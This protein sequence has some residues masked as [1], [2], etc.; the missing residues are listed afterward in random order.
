MEKITTQDK[1]EQGWY[2]DPK[3][4]AEERY[5]N[6]NGQWSSFTRRT[7]AVD[8]NAIMKEIRSI[9]TS[10]VFGTLSIVISLWVIILFR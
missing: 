4:E 10:M 9:K 6:G 8:G 3:G 1:T 5:Y 7:S 2:K